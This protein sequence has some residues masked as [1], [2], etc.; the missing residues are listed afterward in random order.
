VQQ[1]RFELDIPTIELTPLLGG[2]QAK[3]TDEPSL[4]Q[5]FLRFLRRHRMYF[6][7]VVLP[8]MLAAVYFWLLAADRYESEVRFVVRSPSSTAASQL[9]SL[10]QG[11]GIVR[12]SEDAFIVHAFVRSRDAVRNLVSH[13]DLLARM[14]RPEAD[15][16]WQYP[17]LLRR[18]GSEEL[19][20]H[21]QRFL[22]VDYDSTTGITTLRVQAFRPDDARVL[23]EALI[24]QSERL[25]NTMSE[26]AHRDSIRS[27][28]EAVERAREGARASLANISAFRQ[29][30]EMIDPNRTSAV[31]I[32]TM[33]RLALEIARVNAELA[34]MRSQ[35]SDSPQARSL[36]Q[37][38][39]AF[40]QQMQKERAAMAGTDTSL[41]PLIADYE[42]LVLERE[43]AERAFASAQTALD[44]A[45]IDAERQRLFVE[46]ISIAVSTDDPKYPYRFLGVLAVFVI[47]TMLNGVVGW[48][49]QDT[50]SHDSR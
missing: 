39:A 41:A 33:T 13:S 2:D 15:V 42:R 8:T 9:T 36:V 31:A 29:R 37:R 28:S 12:S 3:P 24:E 6:L 50:L 32:E 5:T 45:R 44:L 19:W 30:N 17:G 34:E 47:A 43:F 23:A 16:A 26:R 48:L 25:L 38:A 21:F 27:A 4:G 20:R 14:Q 7:L 40:E 22:S 46:R 11:T 18:A 1:S 10:V 35:A 49:L